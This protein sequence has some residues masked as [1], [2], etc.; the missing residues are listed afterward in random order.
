MTTDCI[1]SAFSMKSFDNPVIKGS[2]TELSTVGE[3]DRS[4]SR[5]RNVESR[6]SSCLMTTTQSRRRAATTRSLNKL[7]NELA[8][9][10][11]FDRKSNASGL[12]SIKSV[13][14]R[15]D[16]TTNEPEIG[17]SCLRFRDDAG[18]DF[19]EKYGGRV[20]R[21]LNPRRSDVDLRRLGRAKAGYSRPKSI[22]R[23]SLSE[24]NET[25]HRSNQSV[26]A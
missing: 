7:L 26:T 24:R 25:R 15:C 23:H 5:A 6:R 16:G 20:V 3:S 4:M 14:L 9:V 10:R 22:D 19:E 8:F 1:R 2:A 12:Y 11:S 18:E 13:E 21:E 17:D